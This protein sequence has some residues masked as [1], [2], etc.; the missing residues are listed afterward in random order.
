MYHAQMGETA[1]ATAWLTE[2]ASPTSPFEV[3]NGDFKF[4]VR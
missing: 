3:A 4:P 1:C 2:T